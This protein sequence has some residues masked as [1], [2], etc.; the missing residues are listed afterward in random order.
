MVAARAFLWNAFSRR[1]S[2]ASALYRPRKDADPYS[3]SRFD[4]I[5]AREELDQIILEHTSEIVDTFDKYSF[6]T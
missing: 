1:A 2:Y 6:M 4:S 3:A 5:K